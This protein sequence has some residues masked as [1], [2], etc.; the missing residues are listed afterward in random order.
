VI[1]DIKARLIVDVLVMAKM[2]VMDVIEVW[3][4]FRLNFG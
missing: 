4:Q 3:H 1:L 2:S